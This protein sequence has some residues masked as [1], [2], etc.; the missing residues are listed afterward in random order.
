[1]Q[2][3]QT[4][5]KANLAEM[6]KSE[7]KT[8]GQKPLDGTL[9]QPTI[10]SEVEP[11]SANN[12]YLK[13]RRLLLGDD[14]SEAI[15]SY[16]SKEQDVERI[17]DDLPKA[18]KESSQ[19]D[20]S[21]TLA[22]VVD[23][24]IGK[25]IQEN[26]TRIT[27]IIF[28]IMGPAVRKAV[29]AA[30]ADMVQS[31]NT[32]LEQSLSFGSLRWRIKAWRSGT[33]YAQYVLLQTIKFRVEQ[34]LL[35]HKETGLLLNSVTA[36]EVEA[37]DPELVSSMLTAISDFVSDS[38]SG[39]QETLEKVRF[40]ELELHLFV[41]PQAVLAIAVRGSASDEV[42]EK[43]HTAIEQIH[44][45]FIQDLDHF[46]GDR[47]AFEATDTILSECLLS[48]KNDQNTKGKP[49]LALIVI[50]GFVSYLVYQSVITWQLNQ[51]FNELESALHN[52][53]G[54]VIISTN[55]DKQ[56]L[57]VKALRSPESLT[58]AELERS[59]SQSIGLDLNVDATVVHFGPLP[60]PVVETKT[61]NELIQFHIN[62]IQNTVF[63]F[64][65]G[66]V[67]LSETELLKIPALIKELKSLE[68]IVNDDELQSLQ[69]I[70]M[71]FADSSGSS[72][73]NNKVSKQRAD[74]I[75]AIL[76]ANGL[77]SDI[78]VSWGV[79]N[80]DQ[81][82]VTEQIQRRV[83]VQILYELKKTQ[84]SDYSADNLSSSQLDKQGASF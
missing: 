44:S 25:S 3:W 27:N 29:S 16:I 7:G 58:V 15:Q 81:K 6:Q 64:E 79:G 71:G 23:K 50:F 59:L 46:E 14:Y 11:A 17:V 45:I 60:K 38:F 67:N 43:A 26:P 54:Y 62:K 61:L 12:D 22:P 31:L 82:S 75:K 41:G 48:Q 30:L 55:R 56:Q 34:V 36:P 8:E 65:P 33:P 19:E 52:Q 35:V 20:L 70:L 18:L 13:L 24:A 2:A 66:E 53:L 49:W 84:L 10:Q 32:L 1:M 4:A 72:N 73:I 77:G 69:V 74:E 40:G 9:D 51:Q 39:G 68:N 63:F 83:T 80:I 42:F 5:W 37:Q 78:I 57:K 76:T 47:T 21:E 28:P